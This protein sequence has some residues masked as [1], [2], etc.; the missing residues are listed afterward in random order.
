MATLTICSG[1]F[2]FLS[3]ISSQRQAFGDAAA[4]PSSAQAPI[5]SKAYLDIS[6]DDAPAGRIVLGL[7]GTV[8]PKT[9][10][11]FEQLCIGTTKAKGPPP[12]PLAY[13]GSTFHRIIPGFM[14]QG[15]DFERHNGTGGRSIYYDEGR[16]VF[17]DEN[18]TLQHQVGVLSMANAG[19]DTNGSQFFITVKGTPHLNGR[20]VVFGVVVEGWDTVKAIERCGS[21]TGRPIARVKVTACGLLESQDA[22]EPSREEK[23]IR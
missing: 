11:N 23:V 17:A 16:Y 5:T 8:V 7:H 4:G 1:T 19:P 10:A 12:Q 18:F 20:H 15:G 9:V 13:Q 21:S 22:E 2:F 14:I 3:H 6:I